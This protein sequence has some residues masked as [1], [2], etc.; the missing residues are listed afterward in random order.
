MMISKSK[1]Y[2]RGFTNDPEGSTPKTGLTPMD[3]LK[4]ALLAGFLIGTTMYLDKKLVRDR[5]KKLN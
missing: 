2:P 1:C 5:Q 4:L 3:Y